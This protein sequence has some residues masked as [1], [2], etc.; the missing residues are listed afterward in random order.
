MRD[1]FRLLA[2]VVIFGASAANSEAADPTWSSVV[3]TN[4]I[5]GV[6]QPIS[7]GAVVNWGSGSIIMGGTVNTEGTTV[8]PGTM[9]NVNAT[10]SPG[11]TMGTFSGT[12]TFTPA[13]PSGTSNGTKRRINRTPEML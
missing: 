8:P 7:V 10:Y 9:T 1:L 11:S 2:I 3:P 5:T 4:G 13:L 12:V 6:G